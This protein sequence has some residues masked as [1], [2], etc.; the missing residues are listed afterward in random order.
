MIQDDDNIVLGKSDKVIREHL[1]ADILYEF[2]NGDGFKWATSGEAG[3]H[4][5]QFNIYRNLGVSNVNRVNENIVKRINVMA[6]KLPKPL[7]LNYR[8]TTFEID[9]QSRRVPVRSGFVICIKSL[10]D[11]VHAPDFKVKFKLICER[12][13]DEVNYSGDFYLRFM[14]DRDGSN[15]APEI[16]SLI[17]NKIY[18]EQLTGTYKGTV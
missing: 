5:I 3:F 8:Y 16:A 13:V 7:Y 1:V 6:R 4:D 15:S 12:S 2:L 17:A 9:S 11:G 14:D 10:D 18:I